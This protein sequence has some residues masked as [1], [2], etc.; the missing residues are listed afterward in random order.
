MHV[1]EE[2]LSLF[3]A[4]QI[5]ANQFSMDQGIYVDREF[6]IE[7]EKARQ[8]LRPVLKAAKGIKE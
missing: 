7:T 5:S 3:D 1:C 4:K 8:L 6:C 2:Q